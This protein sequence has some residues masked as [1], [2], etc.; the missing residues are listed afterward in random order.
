MYSLG[1]WK[2]LCSISSEL[3]GVIDKQAHRDY[4]YWTINIIRNLIRKSYSKIMVHRYH[5]GRFGGDRHGA[6]RQI[7]LINFDHF[8]HFY[9][10]DSFEAFRSLMLFSG[11]HW[12]LFSRCSSLDALH[13]MFFGWYFSLDAIH[14]M[15]NRRSLQLFMER[16]GCVTF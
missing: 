5:S 7:P 10:S 4:N 15:L 13:W 16:A 11:I 6:N 2:A 3:R 12:I 8:D 1:F 14:L 9:H